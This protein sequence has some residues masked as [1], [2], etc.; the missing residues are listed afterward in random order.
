MKVLD[1]TTTRP[2][3]DIR[4]TRAQM[5]ITNSNRVRRFSAKRVAPKMTV[6]RKAASFKV[7]WA[8]TWAQSGRRS[9]A[10]LKNYL[11]Q[12]S[13]R[14]VDQAISR[15]VNNGNYMQHVEA[16]RG[17][18]RN[19]IGEIAWQSYMNDSAVEVNV[20]NM[21][22]TTPDVVW[23]PGYVR[24]EWSTGEM[25]IEWDDNFRP[26]VKVTPHSVEIRLSGYPEV[27]IGVIEKNVSKYNGRKVNR[28]V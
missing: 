19:P 3:L 25:Q 26:D 15:T 21:P 6:E 12:N 8:S 7:D 2:Q 10:Y 20:A 24:I 16:Y 1:I 11:V 22:D 28:R 23:D 27:K 9:P 13:R 17:T 14:K 18:K 5:E 4:S